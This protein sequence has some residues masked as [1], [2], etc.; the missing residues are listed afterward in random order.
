MAHSLSLKNSDYL[1]T[2][3]NFPQPG[4]YT[5][6]STNHSLLHT[7]HRN[8][9]HNNDHLLHPRLKLMV[10]QNTKLI[11][12]A[13]HAHA[14]DKPNTS[15]IG[16]AIHEKTILG[17]HCVT[18]RVPRMLLTT[19]YTITL[20]HHKSIVFVLIHPLNHD[21]LIGGPT[22]LFRPVPHPPMRQISYFALPLLR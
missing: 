19:F 13:T 11:T 16:R 17:N 7:E 5:T 2:D 21:S 22:S 1:R 4:T 20:P 8:S 18:S 14:E 10:N 15:Y 3:L 12:F 9:N 6:S